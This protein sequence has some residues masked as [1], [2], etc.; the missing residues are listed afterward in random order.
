[1]TASYEESIYDEMIEAGTKDLPTPRQI[2][3]EIARGK[4][5]MGFYQW[6]G[7]CE[8]RGDCFEENLGDCF[9]QYPPENDCVK[10]GF[11]AIRNMAVKM[12]E[13]WEARE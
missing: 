5:K 4:D 10:F 7:F 1:M 3:E 8:N 2:L 13:A 6:C 12:I 9:D 11:N